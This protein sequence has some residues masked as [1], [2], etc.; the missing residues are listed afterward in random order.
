MASSEGTVTSA[1][2]LSNLATKYFN[3]ISENQTD[4]SRVRWHKCVDIRDGPNSWNE[5][6]KVLQ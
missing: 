4:T 3:R 2:V 1:N 6:R 5:I